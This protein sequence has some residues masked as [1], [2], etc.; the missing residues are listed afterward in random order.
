MN[1]NVIIDYW[2]EKAR[3]DLASAAFVMG[4]TIDV[5][6]KVYNTYLNLLSTR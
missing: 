3:D 6:I 4:L 5:E 2:L 1:T